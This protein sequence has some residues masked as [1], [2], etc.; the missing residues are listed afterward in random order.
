MKWSSFFCKWSRRF[1]ASEAA[2]HLSLPIQVPSLQFDDRMTD[3]A[4]FQSVLQRPFNT[5]HQNNPSL[6]TQPLHWL[7]VPNC[8]CDLNAE[9]GVG[10][11]AGD[12]VKL[13]FILSWWSD[14]RG[15]SD[16]DRVGAS[17]LLAGRLLDWIMELNPLGERSTY[18]LARVFLRLRLS[19]RTLFFLHFLKANVLV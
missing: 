2:F 3:P 18:D 1:L 9:K 15:M 17:G 6:N 14:L 5:R 11:D 13:E 12:G 7:V 16:R 10:F 4:S 8:P 19:L